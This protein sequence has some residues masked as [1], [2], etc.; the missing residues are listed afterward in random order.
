M[1][2]HRT[3]RAILEARVERLE[4][5]GEIVVDL[6]FDGEAVWIITELPRRVEIQ[7]AFAHYETR[8]AS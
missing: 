6:K 1:P 7:P 4:A 3:G 8:D 5:D 2:V